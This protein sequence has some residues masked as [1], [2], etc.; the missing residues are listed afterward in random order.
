M[1]H[2]CRDKWGH[3]CRLLC[4]KAGEEQVEGEETSSLEARGRRKEEPG[5]TEEITSMDTRV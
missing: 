5:E 1:L 3:K 4:G 2:K